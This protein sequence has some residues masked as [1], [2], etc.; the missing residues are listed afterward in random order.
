MVT[1]HITPADEV[2][3][4]DAGVDEYIRK[5]FDTEV[6]KARIAHAVRCRRSP[7]LQLNELTLD[8][9]ARRAEINGHGLPLTPLE[10]QVL[11]VLV[12]QA[13]QIVSLPD[14]ALFAWGDSELR[15]SNTYYVTLQRLRRKL[16]DHGCSATIRSVRGGGY[17]LTGLTRPHADRSSI[18]DARARV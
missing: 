17:L 2:A 11:R 16:M 3:G 10:F 13:G 8:L 18:I 7:R 5:P 15:A 1:A 4:F 6:F 12:E 9:T 14:L